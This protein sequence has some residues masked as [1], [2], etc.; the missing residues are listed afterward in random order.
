L[1]GGKDFRKA[2]QTVHKF[3][4][5]V[6]YKALEAR[7]DPKS[8]ARDKNNYVFLDALIDETQDPV[9]LRSQLLNILLAGRDTTACCLSWAFRLLARHQHVLEKL[10]REI[11]ET[12]GTEPP[13]QADLKTMFYLH[14]VLKEVLR[15]Y[16]SVPVNSRA[17]LRRTTLPVGGGPLG[18]S[19]TL[20][21][22]GEAVGYCT[23]AMHRRRDIFGEDADDF[24]PE[25]WESGLEKKAGW[26]YLPFNGGPRICLGQ[27]F[28][29]LE[30]GYTIVRV[31][32]A[33]PHLTAIDNP[34][35]AAGDAGVKG[36]VG[37]ERHTLTLVLSSA[38][39]CW[40]EMRR[41][42]QKVASC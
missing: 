27:E 21:R 17:A 31:L 15:L 4:D 20:V 9:F 23:Y 36:A 14:V 1:I 40:M 41:D 39:G 26:A 30:A 38:E 33:F 13:T 6:I 18:K 3:L 12:V 5:E 19:P 2:N 8:E 34:E 32:Q 42:G 24:R 22:K 16:P 28:A 7:K 11:A 10:R 29:L 25:R 37:S 35:M